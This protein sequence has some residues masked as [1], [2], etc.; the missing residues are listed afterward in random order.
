MQVLKEWGV[1]KLWNFNEKS[2]INPPNHVI[3]KVVSILLL[4]CIREIRA[5]WQRGKRG[6]KAI[7]FIQD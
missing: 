3:W 7:V 6:R 2:Q 1:T 4:C 5:T